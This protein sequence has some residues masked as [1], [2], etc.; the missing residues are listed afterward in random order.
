MLFL[1][2]YPDKCLLNNGDAGILAAFPFKLDNYTMCSIVNV[3]PS[4]PINS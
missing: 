4:L 1:V 2:M 3:L